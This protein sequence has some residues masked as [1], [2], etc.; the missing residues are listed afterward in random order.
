MSDVRCSKRVFSGRGVLGHPCSRKGVV[1]RD[2]KMWCRQHDP[3]AEQAKRDAKHAQW[4]AEREAK[5]ARKADAE[6]LAA[7]LGAGQ[8][9]YSTFTGDYT[10]GVM[11]S[12]TEPADLA[13]RLERA[14]RE[15]DELDH[16]RG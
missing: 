3:V 16:R 4:K 13:A 9:Y 12:A 15:R 2:G 11:L 8:P 7:R 1:E 14:E 5:D 10:G 6:R